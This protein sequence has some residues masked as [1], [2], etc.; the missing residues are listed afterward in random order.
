MTPPSHFHHVRDT[1][2]DVIEQGYP[3]A[4]G[5]RG[6][7]CGRRTSGSRALDDGARIHPRYRDSFKSGV[8]V[9][10]PRVPWA[11]GCFGSLTDSPAAYADAVAMDGRILLA[12]DALPY[13]PGWMEGALL[14]SLDAIGRLHQRVVGG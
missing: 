10:R 14:S 1:T 2:R 12:G 11:L 5:L 9:V 13:L 4:G 7:R 3:R 6:K 8:A